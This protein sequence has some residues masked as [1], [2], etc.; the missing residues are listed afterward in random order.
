MGITLREIVFDIGGGIPGGRRFKAA[1]IGGPLGRLHPGCPPRH[2]ASTIESLQE[3]GATMGSGGLVVLDDAVCMV[4]LARSS[5]SSASRSPA[6][7]A[8]PAA[9]GPG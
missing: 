5:W 3:L 4:G 9:S 6:A 8:R 1:Q 7:N 2:A